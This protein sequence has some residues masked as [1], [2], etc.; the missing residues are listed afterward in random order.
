MKKQ[1]L[2]N[3]ITNWL[4]QNTAAAESTQKAMRDLRAQIEGADKATLNNL[5]KQFSALK[6]EATGNVGKS[7]FDQLKSNIAKFTGWY[8]IGNAIALYQATDC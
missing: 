2:S 1:T 8:S 5:K 6:S 7:F 4:R 3:N